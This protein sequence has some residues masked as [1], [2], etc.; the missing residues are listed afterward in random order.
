MLPTL[1]IP[2]KVCHRLAAI[3]TSSKVA[4]FRQIWS[5]FLNNSR[6]DGYIG[7][8]VKCMRVNLLY[9]CVQI[10]STCK[11][12]AVDLYKST[13]YIRKGLGA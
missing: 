8:I 4:K 7:G 2:T 12:N 1:N 9:R 6:I 10:V 5:H 11:R 13:K 3:V